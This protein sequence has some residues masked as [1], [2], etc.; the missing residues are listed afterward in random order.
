MRLAEIGASGL[1]ALA[2]AIACSPP[3]ERTGDDRGTPPAR[4]LLLTEAG[5][6]PARFCMPLD[7]AAATLGQAQDTVVGSEEVQWPA[8][9]VVLPDGGRVLLESSWIDSSH[10]WRVGTTSVA[11]RTRAGAR[12][13][14]T[15]GELPAASSPL[16]V[17]FP[18]GQLVL[19][20]GADSASA[21][22]DTASERAVY[23]HP[24]MDSNALG[25][26]PRTARVRE[27]VSAGSC[28]HRET[29]A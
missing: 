25:H 13:G 22:L 14:M 27:L 11:V 3:D 24:G 2:I 1:V 12:V 7:E 17:E 16:S 21:L 9:V 28:Q 15:V 18:E 29:A 6:G 4:E 19:V 8:K 5:L 23:A 10:L 26:I 20:L